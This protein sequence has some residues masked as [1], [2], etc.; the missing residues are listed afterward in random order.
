MYHAVCCFFS[1]FHHSLYWK[2][3]KAIFFFFTYVWETSNHLWGRLTRR[4]FYLCHKLFSRSWFWVCLR[5][6]FPSGR[7][8]G[9]KTNDESL[10]WKPGCSLHPPPPALAAH[11]PPPVCS[12]H[13]CCH[14]TDKGRL[15]LP[16]NY[17]FTQRP[18]VYF[19]TESSITFLWFHWDLPIALVPGYFFFFRRR[20]F[21]DCTE[22]QPTSQTLQ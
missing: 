4:D 18:D 15:P 16:L 10:N 14:Q 13:F 17:W 22:F 8:Q 21:C 7:C 6:S 12:P 9:K 5:L 11:P 20:F 1:V 2:R 19:L 3:L